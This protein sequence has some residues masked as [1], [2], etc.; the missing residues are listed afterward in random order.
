MRFFT[1]FIKN[2]KK[3]GENLLRI[4]FAVMIRKKKL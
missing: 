1:V 2:E 4:F 3:R